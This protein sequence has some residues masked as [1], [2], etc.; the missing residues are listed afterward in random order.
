MIAHPVMLVLSILCTLF[1]LAPLVL[2][3]V[4]RARKTR[5]MSVTGFLFWTPVK[6]CAGVCGILY[7]CGAF[8]GS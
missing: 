4:S 3:L 1:G 5:V 8:G 7:A 6:L 2:A